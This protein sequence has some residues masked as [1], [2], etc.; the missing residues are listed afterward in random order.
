MKKTVKANSQSRKWI[1][2]ILVVFSL[3]LL[4]FDWWYG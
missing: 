4:F 3:M 2:V 1:F